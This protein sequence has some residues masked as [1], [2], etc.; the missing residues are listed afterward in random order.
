VG[1]V[2]NLHFDKKDGVSFYIDCVR[3]RHGQ[4]GEGRP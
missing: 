3:R 2:D 4:K 1:A